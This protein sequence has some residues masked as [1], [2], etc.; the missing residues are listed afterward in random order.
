VDHLH[1]VAVGVVDLVVDLV[2]DS[3]ESIRQSSLQVV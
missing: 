2:V 1:P 3:N